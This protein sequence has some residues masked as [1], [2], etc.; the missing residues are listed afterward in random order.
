LTENKLFLHD[1]SRD[2]KGRGG[3]LSINNRGAVLLCQLLACVVDKV[4]RA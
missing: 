2:Y 1:N 4:N 3:K